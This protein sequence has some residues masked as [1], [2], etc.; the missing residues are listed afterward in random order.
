MDEE[1][2]YYEEIIVLSLIPSLCINDV[3]M[4]RIH[5]HKM[6]KTVSDSIVFY[7]VLKK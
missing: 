5:K 3:Y 1:I 6:N 7:C 2:K 4:K